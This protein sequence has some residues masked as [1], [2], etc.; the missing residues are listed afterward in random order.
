M[1]EIGPGLGALTEHL[2]AAAG[3]IQ[4]VE[5]DRDLV[6]RLETRYGSDERFN[7]HSGD[8]LKFDFSSLVQGDKKLR[9]VGNLPYN[10]STPLLF[11]LMS[12]VDC[13]RDIHVMLQK[14]VVLRICAQPGD[15]NYGRLSVMLQYYCETQHLF[16]VD[17]GAFNPPPKVESA[18]ARLIPHEKPPVTVNDAGHFA[19][20]VQQAFSMRRK[21]LRNC[22]KRM[23]TVEQIESV[24]IDP[25]I[26]P[27]RLSLAEF[28]ALS[29]LPVQKA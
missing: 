10:I 3:G 2:F 15:N 6:E 24:G 9:V 12:H 20:V 7:I 14:E 28:A 29:N 22:M 26:R 23:L 1:V 25:G 19:A 13:I 11:H 4:V 8:A 16:N 27:E 5:L 21:T 18:I 17:A